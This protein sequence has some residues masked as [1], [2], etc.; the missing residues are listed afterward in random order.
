MIILFGVFKK[1]LFIEVRFFLLIFNLYWEISEI[2]RKIKIG[3][4]IFISEL[5]FF[6]K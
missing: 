3:I 5:F 1:K 4:R 6:L 2:N